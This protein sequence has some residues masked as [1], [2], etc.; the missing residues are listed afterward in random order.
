MSAMTG[1]DIQD[2]AAPPSPD[3][4]GVLQGHFGFESFRPG[5]E[6]V[7]R[8][9]LEC[10][11]VLGVMP[12]GTGK[13]L[14][15]QLTALLRP[16][17]TLVISPLIALMRDQVESLAQHVGLRVALLNST[18]GRREQEATLRAWENGEIT[19][20]YAAP[21][22]FRSRRF[23]DA[24]TRNRP[25]VLAVDEAHCVSQWGHDFR[26]DYLFLRTAIHRLRIPTVM[27][28]TATATPDVQK[29]I[30]AQLGL[31][32]A[33]VVVTGFDRPNLH[34]EVHALATA[35]AKRERLCELLR[36]T[37]G[38]GIV[39]CG[40]R[41][42]AEETT[43]LIRGL[44]RSAATYH[45]D[46]P[47][48]DRAA[49]QTA[50]M[51]DGVEIVAATNAFGLGVNKADIRF[52]FHAA[53]PGTLEALYQ[54]M[55]R[56]GRDGLPARCALLYA[57]ADL[58]LQRFFIQSATPTQSDLENLYRVLRE[59][60]PGRRSAGARPRNGWRCPRRGSG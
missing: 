30:L 39:Y 29:D 2:L 27:A 35:R 36:E 19:L 10:G 22:R 6:D 4:R 34:L 25:Q 37:K 13:S 28:L 43:A 49:T 1:D 26:P 38:S 12:T 45:G 15:Y 20:L 60:G 3:I 9:A 11:R 40:T 50:F 16:G 55:G 7:V 54:E 46:M 41:K 58:S 32:D 18:V 21:E 53:L 57:P 44:G 5:Q 48:A 8:A 31:P 42:Q 33:R 47:A 52:V 14:C 24:L 56:S 51:S 17:G 23:L 59:R